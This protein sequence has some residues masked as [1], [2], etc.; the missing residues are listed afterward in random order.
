[1]TYWYSMYE[2]E[3]IYCT[4]TYCTAACQTVCVKKYG[5]G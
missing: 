4:L 1:M 2:Y 5:S 3:Y